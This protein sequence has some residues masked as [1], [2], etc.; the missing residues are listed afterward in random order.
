MLSPTQVLVRS[1]LDDTWCLVGARLSEPLL[2]QRSWCQL[3]SAVISYNKSLLVFPPTERVF[4]E[5]LVE[6]TPEVTADPMTC[7]ALAPII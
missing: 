3:S 2:M 4:T 1:R 6:Q 7:T 5:L